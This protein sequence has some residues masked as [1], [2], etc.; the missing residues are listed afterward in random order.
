MFE[1]KG[2]PAFKPFAISC[3]KVLFF[4]PGSGVA[5]ASQKWA[6]MLVRLNHIASVIV[7][8]DQGMT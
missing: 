2:V 7:N 8:A 5:H 4:V 1:R 6:R 3:A